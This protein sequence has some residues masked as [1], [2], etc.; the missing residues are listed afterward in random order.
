[1]TV[2]PAGGGVDDFA[3]AVVLQGGAGYFAHA[4][5]AALD[6]A[7]NCLGGARRQR[8]VLQGLKAF[9]QG[10]AIAQGFLGGGVGLVV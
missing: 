5:F 4:H 8:P 10:A 2:S 6:L 3:G 1:M 9:E 7:A